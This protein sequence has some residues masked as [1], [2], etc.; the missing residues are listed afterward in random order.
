MRA[1]SQNAAALASVLVSCLLA[2]LAATSFA[3]QVDV[4]GSIAAENANLSAQ[5]SADATALD[6]ALVELEDLRK[7]K[8]DLEERMQW[9]ERRA[10]VYALGKS[11]RRR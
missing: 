7:A 8:R 9:I 6:H 5:L 4:V 2:L 1:R 3:Q 11:W 10:A